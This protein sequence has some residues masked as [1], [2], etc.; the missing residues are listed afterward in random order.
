MFFFSCFIGIL[1][2]TRRKQAKEWRKGL[3]DQICLCRS[4]HFTEL[5]GTTHNEERMCHINESYRSLVFVEFFVHEKLFVR[6]RYPDVN[7]KRS[8]SREM[9]SEF[10]R[11]QSTSKGYSFLCRKNCVGYQLSHTIP[12]SLVSN[13]ISRVRISSLSIKRSSCHFYWKIEFNNGSPHISLIFYLDVPAPLI[14]YNGC[15][16]LFSPSPI[17]TLAFFLCKLFQTG[18]TNSLILIFPF[19]SSRLSLFSSCYC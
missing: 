15:N 6:R 11:D 14:F 3:N 13:M 19:F 16:T 10:L 12:M 17:N 18:E 7:G 2:Q 8:I 5:L 9:Q 1:E 4:I